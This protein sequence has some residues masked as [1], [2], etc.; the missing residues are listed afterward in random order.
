MERAFQ[1]MSERICL[2]KSNLVYEATTRMSTAST[3]R[4]ASSTQ[5]DKSASGNS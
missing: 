5:A 2:A 4:N 1:E 3:G